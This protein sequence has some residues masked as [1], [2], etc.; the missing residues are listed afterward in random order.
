MS[1]EIDIQ[2]NDQGIIILFTPVSEFAKDW[3]K[4]NCYV[5]SWQWMGSSFG[6]DHRIA[7]DLIA[8]MEEYDLSIERI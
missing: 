8:T 7:S 1:N 4:E 6:V 2:I 5:E 3:V